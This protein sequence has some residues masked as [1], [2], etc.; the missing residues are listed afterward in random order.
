VNRLVGFWRQRSRRG[1]ALLVVVA[2]S[3]VAVAAVVAVFGAFNSPDGETN[4]ASEMT[5]TAEVTTTSDPI[6]CLDGAGLSDVEERDAGLWR[7]FH[8]G[9]SYA[10][11]V[12]KLS[13]P[14]K[15]PT[16]VAGMYAVTG[17]FKVVAEGAGLTVE[18]G[19]EA[20]ALV[21][22]VADCLGG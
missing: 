8:D 5:E 1:K 13:T 10:I 7:G 20:D 15:A 18:E 9:S 12:H 4:V 6:R 16:V 2:V 3:V 11:V 14:A 17:L 19:L 21:Q 22:E